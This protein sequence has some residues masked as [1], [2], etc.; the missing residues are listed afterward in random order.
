MDAEHEG[1]FNRLHRLF[2]SGGAAS[3]GV[4]KSL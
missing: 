1:E 2:P 4:F 3:A